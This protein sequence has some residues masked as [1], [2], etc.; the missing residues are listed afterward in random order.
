MNILLVETGGIIAWNR[1][2]LTP[3][4]YWTLAQAA[5]QIKKNT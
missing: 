3:C 1:S 5:A 4:L 2:K